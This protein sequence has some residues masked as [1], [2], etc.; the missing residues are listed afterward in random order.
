MK[1]TISSSDLLRG[2]NSVSRAISSKSQ[3]PILDNF[4]FVLAGTTLEVTASDLEM[5]LKTTIEIDNVVEEGSVAVP[6][7]YLID[8]IREFPDMPLTLTT[9]NSDKLLEISWAT[10]A[11][12]IPF[13]QSEDY[14]SLPS[15]N[16][17]TLSF[18]I[19]SDILLTGINSTIYATAEEELRPVMNGIFFDMTND[20]IT[21]V[22]SDSHK[23]VYYKRNDISV[24]ENS[25]FILP[26][27]PASILKSLLP[28]VEEDVKVTF[29]QKNAYFEFDGTVLICRLVEGN[30]P[31][32][33]SVIPK[34]HPNKLYIP[35]LELLNGVKRVAVCANPATSHVKFSLSNNKLALSAQDLSFSVSAHETLNCQY[36]GDEF[37]IGFKSTFLAEILSNLPYEEICIE[38]ADQTKA[39]LIVAAGESDPN[40]EICS[41]LMPIRIPS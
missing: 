1:F 12:N 11:S 26:K 13:F 30:Y 22:A 32:Y 6:A 20:S 41:L 21:L 14:P 39:G 36:D 27:K 16:D 35:R 24:N 3:L 38:L 10:G 17:I 9:N 5:T 8:T 18:T 7:K 31:A 23:L 15:L 19:P 40:E 29:D 25:S 4:L 2:L 28:K 34:N 33:K 37:E